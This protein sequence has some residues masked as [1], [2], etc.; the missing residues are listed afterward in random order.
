MNTSELKDFIIKARKSSAI[1]FLEVANTL[2][3]SLDDL[4]D[5]LF[6]KYQF[7][8]S[9]TFEIVD[10]SNVSEK[11]KDDVYKNFIGIVIRESG[12]LAKFNSEVRRP[13]E[14]SYYE[15]DTIKKLNKM[16]KAQLEEIVENYQE[17]YEKTVTFDSLLKLVTK[18]SL[19]SE[20]ILEELPEAVI[21]LTDDETGWTFIGVLG[22][23][24]NSTYGSMPLDE[25]SDRT[26]E[27]YLDKLGLIRRNDKAISD[28]YARLGKCDF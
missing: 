7:R 1:T 15:E 26:S 10:L 4:R 11:V 23:F 22:E 8:N 24:Y 14:I 13:V 12:L 21:Y 9:K 16:S 27:D 2:Y 5:D 25:P 17:N 18:I 28:Y 6:K 20:T 3:E 19:K